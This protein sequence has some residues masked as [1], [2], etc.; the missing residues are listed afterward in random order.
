MTF[1]QSK[2]YRGSTL[3]R[4]LKSS[5]WTN[6]KDWSTS[7]CYLKKEGWRD[8]LLYMCGKFW[9]ESYLTVVWKS[10]I[11]RGEGEKC[12]SLTWKALRESNPSLR[13]ASKLEEQGSSILSPSP[14]GICSRVVWMDLNWTWTNIWNC[15][16]MFLIEGSH[17]YLHCEQLKTLVRVDSWGNC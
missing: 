17:R 7:R 6:G 1:S 3:A 2:I 10:L 12:L 11:V 15:P 4:S 8:I 16:F 13:T 14:W 9:K 5:K